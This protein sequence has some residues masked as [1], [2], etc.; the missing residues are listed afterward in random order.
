MR[1]RHRKGTRLI[2]ARGL[3]PRKPGIEHHGNA[4]GGEIEGR[5]R[6][7]AIGYFIQLHA[8]RLQIKQRCHLQNAATAGAAVI[9]LPGPCLRE[10]GE[11]AQIIGRHVIRDQH[12]NG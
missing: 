3:K 7:A 9:Q 12:H 10:C 6:A 4:P 2:A 1:R 11:F 5:R 8:C